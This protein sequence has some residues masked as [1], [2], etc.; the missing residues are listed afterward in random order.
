LAGEDAIRYPS[1][2]NHPTAFII[3]RRHGPPKRSSGK[4]KNTSIAQ[5]IFD[6][7]LWGVE[8][9]DEVGH[10]PHLEDPEIYADAINDFLNAY[11]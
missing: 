8:M 11:V 9:I 10:M 7:L 6:S 5:R 2:Q 1:L 4:R 3:S